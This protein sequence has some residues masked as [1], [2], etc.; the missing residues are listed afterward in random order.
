MACDKSTRSQ[1]EAFFDRRYKKRI[2]R[3]KKAYEAENGTDPGLEVIPALRCVS[4]RGLV[5]SAFAQGMSEFE[6]AL[7]RMEQRFGLVR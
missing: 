6:V 5:R 2:E 7:E 4:D 3:L 1:Q